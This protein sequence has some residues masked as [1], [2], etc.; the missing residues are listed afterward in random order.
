MGPT[1]LPPAWV[2]RLGVD[3]TAPA[4]KLAEQLANTAGAKAALYLEDLATIPGL[5]PSPLR[6]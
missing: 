6:A 3:A 5:V 4:T 2:E 1:P